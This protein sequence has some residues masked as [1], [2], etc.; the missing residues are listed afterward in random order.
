MTNSMHKKPADG[1]RLAAAARG[2]IGTPF[3]LYGRR[4]SSGLDCVGLVHASMMAIGRT[5]PFVR[6]YR[7]KN[8]SV[9]PWVQHAGRCGLIRICEAPAAGDVLMINSGAAQF[10][11]MIAEN[12]KTVIHAHAGLRRVVRQRMDATTSDFVAQWRLGPT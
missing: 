12:Q 5:P 3:R 11:L 8:I 6:G 1:E 9:D 7:L 10:H 4:P 2:F